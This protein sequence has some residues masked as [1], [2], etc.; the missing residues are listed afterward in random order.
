MKAGM[1]FQYTVAI[2]Y[3]N[4]V[5]YSDRSYEDVVYVGRW[6]HSKGGLHSFI[7]CVD[8]HTRL[9]ANKVASPAPKHPRDPW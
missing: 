2:R 4:I 1:K 3:G 8:P 6:L 5:S 7:E 9:P